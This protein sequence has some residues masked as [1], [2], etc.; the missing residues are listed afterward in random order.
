MPKLEI[1]DLFLTDFYNRNVF[2]YLKLAGLP[3]CLYGVE[4]NIS[5]LFINKFMFNT[6]YCNCV[7]YNGLFSDEYN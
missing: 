4:R 3:S 2:Y 1:S 7:Y 6:F 5:S